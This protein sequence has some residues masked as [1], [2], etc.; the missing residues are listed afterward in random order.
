[1]SSW[2]D[3]EGSANGLWRLGKHVSAAHHDGESDNFEV[4]SGFEDDAG[5]VSQ[6]SKNL[7]VTDEP[8]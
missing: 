1:M 6:R 3:L 7:Y 4:V 8:I 2:V 5:D